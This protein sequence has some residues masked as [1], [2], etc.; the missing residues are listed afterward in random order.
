MLENSWRH[1]KMFQTMRL[2]STARPTTAN[3]LLWGF[4]RDRNRNEEKCRGTVDNERKEA[5]V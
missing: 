4:L 1:G 2:P 5:I 3:Q